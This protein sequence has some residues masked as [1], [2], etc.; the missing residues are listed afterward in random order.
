[1]LIFSEGEYFNILSVEDI[2]RRGMYLEILAERKVPAKEKL[3]GETTN[4]HA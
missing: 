3:D 2:R 4:Q 1:M